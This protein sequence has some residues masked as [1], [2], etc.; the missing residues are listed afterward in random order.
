MFQNISKKLIQSLIGLGKSSLA[1]LRRRSL[2]LYIDKEIDET[3]FR[4]LFRAL[5]FCIHK[6]ESF[7]GVLFAQFCFLDCEKCLKDSSDY[8]D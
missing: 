4:Q 5:Y 8:I 2:T 6:A 3:E 1:I 7:T